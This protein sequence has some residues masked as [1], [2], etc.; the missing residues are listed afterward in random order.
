M[1][2]LSSSSGARASKQ[3][4]WACNALHNLSLWSAFQRVVTSEALGDPSMRLGRGLVV[5]MKNQHHAAHA[6]RAMIN[7]SCTRRSSP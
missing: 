5:V 7:L 1:N 6:V 2:A 3:R 4:L